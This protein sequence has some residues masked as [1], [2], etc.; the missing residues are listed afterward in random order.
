[1]PVP[2]LSRRPRLAAQATPLPP[3]ELVAKGL[4]VAMK[5]QSVGELPAAQ[6][7]QVQDVAKAIQWAS[8]WTRAG[9]SNAKPAS[10]AVVA[11]RAAQALGPSSSITPVKIVDALQAQGIDWVQPFPPGQ[12]LVPYYGYNRRPRQYNYQVGRNITT[13]TR[14][15][16]IPFDTLE[17]LFDAYDVA[18]F[19]TRYAINDLR[20]MRLR[21][22]AMDGYEDN[23]VKEI[24]EAKRRL[25][26]P[27]GKRMFRNWL[28]Q[29]MFDLWRFDSAPIFRLRDKAG[30]VKHLKNVSAKTMAVMV[31]YY[32]DFP[33][34]PA[35]AFNQMIE[36]IP[37]DWLSW[38][39]VIY[40]PFWPRTDSPYGTPPLETVLVNANTDLRL[41]LYFL[42]FFTAGAVPEAFAIAP[43][44]MSS[45]DD[46]GDFQEW[47]DDL[48]NGDQADRW[49]LKWL[50]GGTEL[51]FY[52]PQTFDPDLAEYVMR[53]TVAA[54]GLTP[55]NLGILDDVNRA[56]ADTQ[57]DQQ[58]RVTTLPIV[59]YYEDLLDAVLQ[60]DWNLPVQVRFDTGREKEDRLVEAQAHQIYVQLGAESPDEV[61]EKVLGYPVNPE[62][63]IPRFIMDERLG[64]I[65]LA[66]VQAVSGDVDPLTG[67]P[68]PGTVHPIPFEL[69]GGGTPV[70]AEGPQGGK[71][72]AS[73]GARPKG[74][75]PTKTYPD[76]V[77]ASG[78]AKELSGAPPED[79]TP[80][81]HG[82]SPIATG[83]GRWNQFGGSTAQGTAAEGPPQPLDGPEEFFPPEVADLRRWKRAA[84]K[85]V[86][87]GK[88]PRPFHDSAISAPVYARVWKHL[89]GATSR[90]QVDR[91]FKAGPEAAGIV[92]QAADSGRVLM[93]RRTP[94][95]HDPDEAYARW[96]WPG[97]RLDDGESPWAGALREWG[98]ETGA[99]LVHFTHLGNWTSP[100]G[101]YVGFVVEV[102]SERLIHLDP[103]G[104]EVS[105]ARWR[106]VDD[107]DHPE[108]REKVTD[109]LDR[110]LPLLKAWGDQPRRRDGKW[111]TQSHAEWERFHRHTDIIVD[112]YG[113]Q[114]ADAMAEVFTPEFLHEVVATAYGHVEK[115]QPKASGRGSGLPPNQAA[116]VAGTA[117]AAAAVPAAAGA[118]MGAASAS[119]GAGVGRGAVGVLAALAMLAAG[120]KA[121]RKLHDVLTRLYGDAYMQ[122]AHEAAEAASGEMPPWTRAVPVPE[123]YWHHWEPGIG[124][125]ASNVAGGALS[126]ILRQRDQWIREITDTEV[127]RIGE[128]IRQCVHGGKRM[129][130]CIAEVDGIVHDEKRAWLIA[131]TEYCRAMAAAAMET[132]RLNRVPMLKWLHEPTAC[133]LCMENAAASPQPSADP[134]WPN[135]GLP[136]HPHERCAVAP[137]YP[138][139]QRR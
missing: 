133:H 68:M 75:D 127:D 56:T 71:P 91:A 74:S 94:D 5:P 39:D 66:H 84:R 124:R 115:A 95:K 92:V 33:D 122:G 4:A 117:G 112:H 55:Q 57:V 42:Q 125:E 82:N 73:A 106:P 121:L 70:P 53:R 103:D 58:F 105:D 83:Y 8:G 48:L 72:A 12:P 123:G 86:E 46:L 116:A 28:A 16:R 134:R 120:R 45:P 19:C 78:A 31:D 52:K 23:P 13:E 64:V 9:G 114:V 27:D 35:P 51:Q 102:P 110:V 89:E 47:T 32:G 104:H 101:D 43:E 22:E 126:D 41:Q 21:F 113:P 108:I 63:R 119:L 10:A 29:N 25:R 111:A 15:D 7:D 109:D 96:E 65:P 62:E 118:A 137:Y 1:M 90:E 139:T 136:V 6:R 98:E 24:A 97:G 36:G 38:D 93:V 14:P 34:A 54:F 69:P 76:P 11:Q 135:G 131:E 77:L 138:P 67:A 18:Q 59:G 88:T 3:D 2:I 50:P 17:R 87:R 26:R 130:E 81:K 60:D 61:R 44:K 129:A 128:A 79:S 99:A 132:Y 49:G 20:S 107:L 37:W 30:N 100:D 80:A 40:E 85:A